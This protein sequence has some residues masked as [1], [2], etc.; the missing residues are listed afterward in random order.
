MT[1]REL[2]VDP[3]RL[4]TFGVPETDLLV[5][6]D[7][8]NEAALLA[9]HFDAIRSQAWLLFD[10]MNALQIRSGNTAVLVVTGVR[11]FAWARFGAVRTPDRTAWSL[12]VWAP[13][14]HAGTWSLDAAFAPDATLNLAGTSAEIHVGNVPGGDDSPPDYGEVDDATLLSGTASWDSEFDVVF[15]TSVGSD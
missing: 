6:V 14:W 8:L 4:R 13:T 9:V 7:S 15:S 11:E 2:I 5:R 10:C 12:V 3:N 1:I